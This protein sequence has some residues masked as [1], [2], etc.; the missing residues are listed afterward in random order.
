MR[1]FARSSVFGPAIVL[2]A[3]A[4]ALLPSMRTSVSAEGA[5]LNPAECQWLGQH[6]SAAD[7]EAAGL[8][9]AALK[10][11]QFVIT[12]DVANELTLSADSPEIKALNWV[13][14]DVTFQQGTSTV[15][16]RER[17]PLLYDVLNL[18]KP[19][20]DNTL[21]NNH[22]LRFAIT[23]VGSDGYAATIGWGEIDPGFGNAGTLLSFEEASSPTSPL[24]AL[25]QPRVIGLGDIRGGRYVS[26]VVKIIVEEIEP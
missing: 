19:N 3:L 7:L 11:G 12:G 1:R 18:A 14:T 20:F 9:P 6:V 24:V 2:V 17:G 5:M 21:Q 15:T 16:R 26:L 10:A 25:D 13:T 23:A 4:C 8:C 22:R